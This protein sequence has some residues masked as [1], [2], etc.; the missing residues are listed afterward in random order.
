MI[1]FKKG[2]KM[3]LTVTFPEKKSFLELTFFCE[4]LCRV[5]CA[6]IR[7]KVKIEPRKCAHTVSIISWDMQ[8]DSITNS[9]ESCLRLKLR[10]TYE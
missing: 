2:L 10:K 6:E 4:P 7:D 1:F 8:G 5:T 3:D 9:K